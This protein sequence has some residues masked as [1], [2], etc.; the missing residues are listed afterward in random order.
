MP[1]IIKSKF[2]EGRGGIKIPE[3]SLDPR[4]RAEDE[5][6]RFFSS[7]WRENAD[8]DSHDPLTELVVCATAEKPLVVVRRTVARASSTHQFLAAPTDGSLAWNSLFEYSFTVWSDGANSDYISFSGSTE[9]K[10]ASMKPWENVADEED[11]DKAFSQ[12]REIYCKGVE[13]VLKQTVEL[14]I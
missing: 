10:A 8:E 3:V 9:L 1:E 2:I 14:I 4:W 13:Q 5:V 6:R 11:E 7:F 12:Q